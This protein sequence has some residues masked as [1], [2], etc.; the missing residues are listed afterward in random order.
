M[1][2]AV[3]LATV[4]TIMTLY[5]GLTQLSL[6]LYR[7]QSSYSL[8]FA[9][10]CGVMT[11]YDVITIGYYLARSPEAAIAWQQAQLALLALVSLLLLEFIA[12]LTRRVGQAAKWSFRLS[13]GLLA[14]LQALNPAGLS[15]RLAG[16]RPLV[17]DLP[18]ALSQTYHPAVAGPLCLIQVLTGCLLGLYLLR[19]TWQAWRSDQNRAAKPLFICTLI[20]LIG[21]LNDSLVM[22]RMIASLY[23]LELAY[24]S[25][26]LAVTY[27]M[28]TAVAQA[29]ITSRALA[30]TEAELRE[31]NQNLETLVR[32][33]TAELEATNQMLKAE[34]EVRREFEDKLEEAFEEIRTISITDPL[35]S[36]FNRRYLTENLPAE[37]KRAE[38]YA[39][40]LCLIMCDIDHFKQVNDTHGHRAGDLVLS[41]FVHNLKTQLRDK[42]DWIAR[43]GGEEFVITLPE[44]QLAD[45]L[46]L[47]ERLRRSVHAL[48]VFEGMNEIKITASFGVAQLTPGQ[49]AEDLLNAAD[50]ELYRAKNEGRDCV[51]PRYGVNQA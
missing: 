48:S 26:I 35:T 36:S 4:C 13:L 23:L 11:V 45:G 41:A 12:R 39:S 42:I 20:I 51:R 29:A 1:N 16:A 19:V 8:S 5:M 21:L 47:A 34:I 40:N 31:L 17:V 43:Y 22:S 14:L 37:I 28:V 10:T 50:Q 30:Q 49:K 15:W 46:A 7:R 6:Y 27:A 2:I 38:R 24:L 3:T 32:S 18:G 44:S 25:A 33:R 9:L